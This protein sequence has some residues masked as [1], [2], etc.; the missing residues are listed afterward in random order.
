MGSGG[1]HMAGGH[2]HMDGCGMR[3]G[4]GF[5]IAGSISPI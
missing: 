3:M 2:A 5:Q 4:G 1:F